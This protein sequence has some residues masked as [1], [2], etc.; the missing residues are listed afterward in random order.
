MFLH[1]AQV[2]FGN[3]KHVCHIPCSNSLSSDTPQDSMLNTHKGL[4][5]DGR[6][7]VLLHRLCVNENMVG[8]CH[9]KISKLKV[10][11]SVSCITKDHID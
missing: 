9:Y 1:L 7:F 2:Y 6:M 3:S 11:A 5:D 4:W 8:I 10:I